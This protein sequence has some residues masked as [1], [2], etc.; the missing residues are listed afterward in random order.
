MN[1]NTRPK[2]TTA[3]AV[4][5]LIFL[6]AIV[7]PKLIFNGIASKILVT[8]GL[9]LA[10]S[11]LAIVI[12][13]KAKFSE[14]G[15]CLPKANPQSDKGKYGWIGVSLLAP[16][17]GICA[18][19]LIL[20]LGGGGNPLVRSLSIPQ[21][22][23]FVW[24]FSSIIEEIFTRGFLQSHLSALSG[25]SIKLLFFKIEL[26]VLISALFFGCMHFVLFLSGVDAIT[27][28][29][30]FVFTF[31][32]GLMAGTLRAGTG[33]LLPAITVH[34]LANIG[35]MIGGIIYTVINFMI[36]GNM[37]GI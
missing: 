13:G 36:T 23:L 28:A 20:G 26:P 24:I 4:A 8:Q 33:S 2:V 10:L 7:L 5:V 15:F 32:I 9:E 30:T 16:L 1:D 3:L 21:I 29:V 11:L 18:T 17:L 31:S 14:Y 25:K 22:V 19:P 37:P 35:G 34:I 27:V 12:F 6:I